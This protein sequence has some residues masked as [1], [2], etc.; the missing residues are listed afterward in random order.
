MSDCITGIKNAEQCTI[1]AQED[2]TEG[3]DGYLTRVHW[4][5]IS[6]VTCDSCSSSACAPKWWTES[7]T[8]ETLPEDT[9]SNDSAP[10]SLDS[11]NTE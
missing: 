5:K 8:N 9:S 6:K 7:R 3:D 10:T 4:K 2:C 11:S 1:R